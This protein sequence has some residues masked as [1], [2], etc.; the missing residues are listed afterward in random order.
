LSEPFDVAS[1]RR[2]HGIPIMSVVNEKLCI[3]ARHGSSA[4]VL[5]QS[6]VV[7]MP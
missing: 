6:L 2:E 3:S 1:R 5:Q 4:Y 7:V